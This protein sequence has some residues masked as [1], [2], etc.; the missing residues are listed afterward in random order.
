MRFK[1][2][3]IEITNACNLNCPFCIKNKRKI[4]YITLDNYKL[5]ISKIKNYTKEIY[6]HILGEPLL[7][8]AIVG[9]FATVRKY[10]PYCRVALLTNG[11]LLGKMDLDFWRAC[12][13]Y[14]ITLCCT[15]Y[16]V[17]VNW[18]QVENKAAE[19]GLHI[20]YHNDVGAGEKT[21]IK[22]PFDLDG[23]QDIEWNYAHCTRSNKCITLKN[24][25]IYTCPMAAHAHLVKD[26]FNLNI[27]LLEEDS[28][29]IYNAKSF[30]EIT[31]FLVRP[32]PFCRYCNLKKKSEQIEW[33]VSKREISEWF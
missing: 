32:I 29:N 25:K 6:L 31:Q 17:I 4:N 20:E 8:P 2:I 1:K 33:Q 16:P 26:Y 12:V 18:M 9:F 11:T 28:I 13:K 15:K 5:I 22:Y 27:E 10:F 24:G 7:H 23:K 30:E 19:F 3:Y 14:H 21:L